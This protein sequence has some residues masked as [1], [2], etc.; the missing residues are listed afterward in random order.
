MA[1]QNNKLARLA[2]ERRDKS[3]TGSFDFEP[4]I[5]DRLVRLEEDI[6][7]FRFPKVSSSTAK[8]VIARFE[9]ATERIADLLADISSTEMAA[10]AEF[11]R[12]ML[13]K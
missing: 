2:Q 11:D 7:R 9:K 6:R 10:W 8:K 4:T 12:A 13:G 1:L 3:K 5:E